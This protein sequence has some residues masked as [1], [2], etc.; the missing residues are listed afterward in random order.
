ML[1][2]SLSTPHYS[3]SQG[4]QQEKTKAQKAASAAAGGSKGGKKKKWSKGRVREKAQNLVLFD[5]K[6]H[7]RLLA[8][9]PKMKLITPSTIIERL[10]ING[11]LAR[12]AIRDLESKGIIKPV[13][14]HHTQWIYTR[15]AGDA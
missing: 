11:S 8:E 1:I 13:S 4:K 2:H 5:A 9:V 7:K 14:V 12:A 3:V 15:T 6:T 10:K